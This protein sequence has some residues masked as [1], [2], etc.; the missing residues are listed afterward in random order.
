MG[1][2]KG[3]LIGAVSVR[4]GA[5]VYAP[6]KRKKHQNRRGDF[7]RKPCAERRGPWGSDDLNQVSGFHIMKRARA[8]FGQ[9]FQG[10]RHRVMQ[11]GC[12]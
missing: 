1:E 3:I 10:K 11:R 12:G 9:S 4:K 5:T 2:T 6:S 7:E 8:R